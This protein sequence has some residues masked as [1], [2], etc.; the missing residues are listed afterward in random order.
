[1]TLCVLPS[2]L[3]AQELPEVTGVFGD[4]LE[5]L[6]RLL[7]V[8]MDTA[9]QILTQSWN[10]VVRTCIKKKISLRAMFT[11]GALQL[12][13]GWDTSVQAWRPRCLL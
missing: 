9:T 7:T 12:A 3:Y 1:M 5:R 2:L 8:D 11:G 4:M 13:V 10:L 6:A